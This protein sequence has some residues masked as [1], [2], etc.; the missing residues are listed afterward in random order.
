MYFWILGKS[1]GK[2]VLMGPY[3]SERDARDIGFRTY[4]GGYFDTYCLDTKDRTRATQEIKHKKLEG[5]AT[6]NEALERIGHVES[7]A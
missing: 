6:L 2:E 1:L 7:D 3:S 5:G 4:D